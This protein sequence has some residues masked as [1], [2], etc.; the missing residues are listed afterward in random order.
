MTGFDDSVTSALRAR[1]TGVLSDPAE[2]LRRRP[3]LA[4]ALAAARSGEA[5]DLDLSAGDD[6][7]VVPLGAEPA[8]SDGQRRRVWVVLA[9][10]AAVVVLVGAAVGLARAQRP[11]GGAIAPAMT[12]QQAFSV[13]ERPAMA[14]DALPDVGISI[15]SLPVPGSARVLADSAA[16]EYWAALDAAGEVCLVVLERTGA[17]SFTTMCQ[18]VERAAREGV[19][20]STDANSMI[21]AV[22]VPDSFDARELQRAGYQRIVANLW[23]DGATASAVALADVENASQQPLALQAR[24]GRGTEELPSFSVDSG[25]FSVVVRCLGPA[26]VGLVING[27]VLAPEDCSDGMRSVGRESDGAPVQVRVTADPGV[28]WAAGVIACR[29]DEMGTYC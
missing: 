12:V 13:L 7:H 1:A 2:Q 26:R 6:A 15:P 21:S 18:P 19:R 8:T 20:V 5:E 4:A 29:R 28:S 22:L 10:A 17:P 23:V 16:A 14:A 9:A 24:L 11:D 25:S 3:D 27:E